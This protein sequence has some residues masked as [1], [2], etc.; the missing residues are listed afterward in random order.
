MFRL[1]MEGVE[2]HRRLD[3]AADCRRPSTAWTRPI[4][5]QILTTS[6]IS[7]SKSKTKIS[8]RSVFVV[9]V[10]ILHAVRHSDSPVITK[11]D[12]VFLPYREAEVSHD[13][14]PFCSFSRRQVSDLYPESFFVRRKEEGCALVTSLRM[15]VPHLPAVP[16]MI[17]MQVQIQ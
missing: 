12:C 2:V 14:E 11:N 15:D 1:H 8:Q 9:F 10:S 16:L 4:M 17:V 3:F 7:I 13:F 5:M 6:G